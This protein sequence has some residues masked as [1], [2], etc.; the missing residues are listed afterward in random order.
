MWEI[1][2]QPRSQWDL[3]TDSVVCSIFIET[4]PH[5]SFYD[6][7]RFQRMSNFI[8]KFQFCICILLSEENGYPKWAASAGGVAYKSAQVTVSAPTEFSGVRLDQYTSDRQRQVCFAVAAEFLIIDSNYSGFLLLLQQ[9]KYKR[10]LLNKT[11]ETRYISTH[12]RLS[13]KKT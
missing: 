7:S 5:F 12:N 8:S 11:T 13:R 2:D 4:S 1:T 6:I 9:R 10:T 3:K